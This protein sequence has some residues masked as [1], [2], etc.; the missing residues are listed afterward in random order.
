MFLDEIGDLPLEAQVKLLRVL[1]SGEVD[2]LGGEKSHKVDVRLI[3]ATNV[4]LSKAVAEKRFREDLFYRI[5]PF[6][7]EI[8]PLRE[9]RTD[10]PLFVAEL[11]DRLTK[12][13]GKPIRGLS[14]K[15]METL[16]HYDWPGNVRELENVLERG[17]ML[18]EPGGR[19]ELESLFLSQPDVRA[20]FG[21]IGPDGRVT[22]DDVAHGGNDELSLAA[23]EKRLIETALQRADGNVAEA[24]KLLGITRRQ[25]DYRLKQ[26]G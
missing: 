3:S 6:P 26:M 8:P 4:N 5:S 18:A 20:A 21:A 1:Q 14:D 7:V 22:T 23:N 9:R 16:L 24:A 19:I 13:H 25:I 15:A 17:V 11:I 10:I 12:R 2:R